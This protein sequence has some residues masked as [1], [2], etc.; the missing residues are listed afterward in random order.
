MLVLTNGID[1]ESFA[2]DRTRRK[3][4][5]TEMGAGHAF[6]WLA[7]GRLVPAKDYA[8]L[9]RAFEQVRRANPS[10]RLWIAGEGDPVSLA[11]E[12]A[13]AV[14]FLG[15][16]HDIAAL[17]DAADGFVLSSAWEGM[18]LALG[19]AMAMEKIVVATDVGGVRELIGEAGVIVPPKNSAALAE[20]MLKAMAMQEMERKTMQRDARR[21]IQMHYSM[22][23]KAEEWEQ[24]YRQFVP[25]RAK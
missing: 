23:V 10:A 6:V 21:R 16:R 17:L 8:N 7:V 3:R 12:P 22:P 4:T 19:E 5:R 1:A 15:L 24:L 14:E 25:G 18:P 13:K 20:A 9:L 2:P 11:G